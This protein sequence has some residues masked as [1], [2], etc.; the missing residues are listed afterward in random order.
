MDKFITRKKKKRR[1]EKK[2]KKKKNSECISVYNWRVIRRNQF[3]YF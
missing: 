1:K 3:N 2:W